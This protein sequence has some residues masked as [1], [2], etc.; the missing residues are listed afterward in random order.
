MLILYLVLFQQ[1]MDFK[2][3]E[4]LI[5][6]DISYANAV[7]TDAGFNYKRLLAVNLYTSDKYKL[8]YGMTYNMISIMTDEDEIVRDIVIHFQ[9]MI[10][11]SFYDLF[12]LNYGHPDTIQIID[13]YDSVGDW[14]ESDPGEEFSHRVRKVTLKTREG[15]FEEN[16]LFMIWKK[17]GYQIKILMKQEQGI[18][19]ITFRLPTEKL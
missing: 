11:N 19:E 2:E 14:K 4:I 16:P 9:S 17:E 13:G 10:D 15:K 7:L 5:G 1:T 18:S 12:S 8:F 3:F 6:K